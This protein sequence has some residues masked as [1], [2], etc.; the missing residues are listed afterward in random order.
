MQ[1]G[2]RGVPQWQGRGARSARLHG[3]AS[4]LMVSRFAFAVDF[5][6]FS[7][8]GDDRALGDGRRKCRLVKTAGRV[9]HHDKVMEFGMLSKAR[10]LGRRW[11]GPKRGL[12]RAALPVSES[13]LRLAH[14][15]WRQ[16]ASEA[17][18]QK[19]RKQRRGASATGPS[20]R[21]GIMK[22]IEMKPRS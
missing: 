6:L 5:R 18:E 9:V 17:F 10:I 4:G 13:V 16:M 11:S 20:R 21:I 14:L 3:S 12:V 7:T 1:V 19:E 8:D 22:A 2:C 15:I